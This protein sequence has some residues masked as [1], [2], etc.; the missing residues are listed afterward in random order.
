[1]EKLLETSLGH[2]DNTWFSLDGK[3]I[4]DEDALKLIKDKCN[5][6]ITNSEGVLIYMSQEEY[7]SLRE[8]EIRHLNPSNS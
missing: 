5:P 4:S 1:M 2:W 8:Q 7:N 6:Y 3:R